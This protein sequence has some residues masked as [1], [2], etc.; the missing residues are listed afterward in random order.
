V[1]HLLERR[2]RRHLHRHH[3]DRQRTAGG[4][5]FHV[6]DFTPSNDQTGLTALASEINSRRVV[7]SGQRPGF[8]VEASLSLPVR[9]HGLRQDLDCDL[10]GQVG[11]GR[12]IHFSHAARANLG[13]DF[14]RAEPRTWGEGHGRRTGVTRHARRWAERSAL[15]RRTTAGVGFR[16]FRGRGDQPLRFIR[17]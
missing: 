11:V 6:I 15:D 16:K 17:T 12:P 5:V 8:T 9:G 1:A 3:A 2:R 7:Q 14:I 10:T 4:N 13:A